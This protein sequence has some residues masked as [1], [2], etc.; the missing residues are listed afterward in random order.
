MTMGGDGADVM[1]T[2]RWRKCRRRSDGCTSVG[3]NKNMGLLVFWFDAFIFGD[4][5]GGGGRHSMLQW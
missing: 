5:N 1:T 2:A 3:S 4:D